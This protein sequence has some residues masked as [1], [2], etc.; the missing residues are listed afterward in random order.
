[1]ALLQA[2]RAAVAVHPTRPRLSTSPPTTNRETRPHYDVATAFVSVSTSER[3]MHAAMPLHA[4]RVDSIADNDFRHGDLFLVTPTTTNAAQLN[5]PDKPVDRP[6]SSGIHQTAP[7]KDN[8]RWQEPGGMPPQ[9]PCNSA[10]LRENAR[11]RALHQ[12]RAAT[13][14]T[15]PRPLPSTRHW[16]RAWNTVI[17]AAPACRF[18]PSAWGQ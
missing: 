4:R 13:S 3:E 7:R 14:T 11:R 18:H 2:P 1:M 10:K 12:C 17:S 8:K 16:I 5:L 15:T 6:K 9:L